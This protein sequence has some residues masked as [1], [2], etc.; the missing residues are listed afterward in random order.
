VSSR[1]ASP[2]LRATSVGLA[3]LIAV[4]WLSGGLSSGSAGPS[5]GLTLVTRSDD[6][7]RTVTS[8]A[9]ETAT[10]NVDPEVLDEVTAVGAAV[11]LQTRNK[12]SEAADSVYS[13]AVGS[14]HARVGE[15]DRVVVDDTDGLW[16]VVDAAGR[17]DGGVVLSGLAG[18][19]RSRLFTVPSGRQ[20]V[21]VTSDG[22][23]TLVGDHRDRRLQVW[24][25]LLG[26]VMARLGY[27][28]GVLGVHQG[29]VL[30]SSGCLSKGCTTNLI[31]TATGRS[32]PVEPPAGWTESG[33]AVLAPDGRTVAQV[34]AAADGT[35]GLALGSPSSMT[36]VA[37]VVPGVAAAPHFAADGWLV[38][39]D[40]AGDALLVRGDERVTVA[41]GVGERLVAVSPTR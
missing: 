7:L 39:T 9:G 27:V 18:S 25:P 29:R 11:V 41:L 31:D 30:A 5:S 2:K 14:S 21:G 26:Q 8:D 40:E 22:L 28:T 16:L 23:V 10:L 15:A 34:V 35:Q 20:V 36:V 24:N 12:R 6:G 17:T 4:A 32:T 1:L 13:Y 19:S 33:P 38:V 37:D 3:V